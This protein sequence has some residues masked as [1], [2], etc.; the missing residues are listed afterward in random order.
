MLDPKSRGKRVFMPSLVSVV[1]R[2]EIRLL[3]PIMNKFSITTARAFQEKLGD[4]E[5]KSVAAKVDFTFFD[6]G[7]LKACFA[8]SKESYKK[9]KVILYLHGGAYVAGDIQYARGFAGVLAAETNRRVLSIAYRLAPEA[10]F[11][12]AV[13]DAV[14]AYEYLLDHGYTAQ[15][16]SLVGESAGGGL[17]YCL[18]LRLKQKKMPLPAALVAISP[19]T[20]LTFSGESYRLNDK[21]DPSLLED[22]LREHA[23]AYAPGQEKN[24]LVSPVF[25]DLRHFAPVSFVCRR[26]RAAFGRC[27][28]ACGPVDPKREPLRTGR[29]RR[30]LARLCFVPNTRGKESHT[31]NSRFFGAGQMSRI[32]Q[33]N[34]M[35]LDNAAKI[36][37]A[38][39]R[40]KWKALFRLSASL[41]EEID[42]DVLALAQKSTLARFPGFALE[43]KRGVFWYYLEQNDEQPDIRQDT[44]YPCA[45]MDFRENKGFMFR[46]RYYRRRIAVEIFHALTDGTGGIC[47]LKTLVAE[48][49]RIK[50]AAEIPRGQ[51]ILDCSQIPAAEETEDAYIKYAKNVRRTRREPNAYHMKGTEEN[52]DFV[53]I[54]SGIIPV[55]AI[56]LRAKENGVTLTEYLTA[57]MITA[58]DKIQRQACKAENRLK[59]V[60][61]CIPINLRRFYPT[62]T[63]RNFSIYVNPGI[64]P[65]YGRYSF[66][67]VLS[68]V[69]HYM[70]SE[71]TEKLLNAKISTNVRSEN[72]KVLRV[73]PLFIKNMAMKF[74]FKLVGDRK[75]SITISNLGVVK[76]P[77]QMAQYVTRM[78]F[79]LGPPRP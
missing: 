64:D 58:A 73:A 42:P 47:F 20:D 54:I 25:G 40:R 49:L 2:E 52:A 72:N 68:A 5:A 6:I 63:M 17:I 78:D 1:L 62:N 33:K 34:W 59:P 74:T 61:V 14:T 77:A 31:E 18:C 29:R 41:T 37:P 70:R 19:W 23:A 15:N 38:A 79:I 50:Y 12:A 11:P 16:I 55:N 21:K 45:R 27:Q 24:P 22:V 60:K 48:Y 4:M 13:D 35:K 39:K 67:E 44:A 53:N 28:D 71:V 76:L 30:A 32:H 66:D 69:H 9:E 75:S 26:R 65:G 57:V 3:K 36:Y 56:L 10:P 43:L 8:S 51:E 7:G 46:V